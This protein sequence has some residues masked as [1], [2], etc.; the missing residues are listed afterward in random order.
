[1]LPQTSPKEGKRSHHCHS[2]GEVPFSI[3]PW[4]KQPSY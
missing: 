3:L 1:M 4:E 2:H